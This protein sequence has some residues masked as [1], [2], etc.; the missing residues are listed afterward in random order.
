M[1]KRMRSLSSSGSMWMSDARSRIA[2]LTMR[3]TNWMI[4]AWS[5]RL[6]SAASGGHLA[7]VVADLEVLDQSLDLVVRLDRCGR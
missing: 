4:G 3:L 1:R 2:W 7:L 6:T 5:S